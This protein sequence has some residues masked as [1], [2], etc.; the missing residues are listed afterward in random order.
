MIKKCTRQW[1]VKTINLPFNSRNETA[2]NGK[3]IKERGQK[4]GEICNITYLQA[5]EMGFKKINEKWSKILHKTMEMKTIN[6]P[7][8]FRLPKEENGRKSE[9]DCWGGEEISIAMAMVVAAMCFLWCVFWHQPQSILPNMGA[10]CTF[11]STNEHVKYMYVIS[12]V[13]LYQ[14]EKTNAN[15]LIFK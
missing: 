3:G 5:S 12:G 2:L 8:D 4:L 7:F 11:V 15:S 6:L 10:S 14:E 9:V 13:H 1:R